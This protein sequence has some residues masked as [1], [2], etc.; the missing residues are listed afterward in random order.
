MDAPLTGSVTAVLIGLLLGLER[1]RAHRNEPEL[2]AG[3][4]TFPVLTLGGY[5]A[6]TTGNHLVLA[7]FVLGVAGLAIAA[8]VR[9]SQGQVGATTEAVAVAAPVLGALVQSGHAMLAASAAVMIALLLT[10]KAPLHRLAGSVSEEEIL[11][12]LKFGV[13]AVILLPLLPTAAVGPYGAIVPRHVGYVVVILCAVSLG[14]YLL[15]R[16]LGSRLGW[17]LAGALGGL[18]SSTAVTLSFAGKARATPDL[19]R[20]LAVGVVLAST[21]LY[22][23]GLLLIAV[24]DRALAFHL[25]P[26]LL[27]LFVVGLGLAFALHRGATTQRPGVVNLG[28]PVELGRAFVLAGLFA[29]IL[30]GAR[31]AQQEFGTSGLQVTGL[32]GGLVDVDSVAVAVARLRQQ[33]LATTEAAAVAYLLAT[34]ANLCVKAGIVVIAGGAVLARHV[35]APFGVLA[36]VTAAVLLLA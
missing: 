5:L 6:A 35:L 3:I 8:Y 17:A 1:E 32:V 34:L 22:L 19:G 27:G 24:F 7:A 10:L 21:V 31:A 15:V 9:T 20:P 13:V 23:R 25:A 33:G 2:F 11:S 36:A 30:V 12:I 4:R 18:V 29:A 14:G 28:N 26:R 16:I